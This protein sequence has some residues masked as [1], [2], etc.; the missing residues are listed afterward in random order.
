MLI[1]FFDISVH[2]EFVLVGQTVDSAYTVTPYGYYVKM[3]EDLAPNFGDKRINWLR[4]NKNT[5]VR[6]YICV[7]FI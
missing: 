1:I 2:K 6:N 4:N 5:F 7:T 3:R